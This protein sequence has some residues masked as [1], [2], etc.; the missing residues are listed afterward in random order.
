MNSDSTDGPRD[1]R[2]VRVLVLIATLVLLAA[3]CGSTATGGGADE[4]GPAA[5]EGEGDS[6]QITM[7]RATW[8]TGFMQSYIYRDLLTELGF[9][10]SD[11]SEATLD[12]N[13]FYPALGQ[14][15]YDLWANGWF[16][17]HDIY[18]ERELFSG[19][20]NAEPISPVGTEVAGGAL[21]GYLV[22]R[23]TA[24]EMNLTSMSDLADADV[25]TTFDGNGNG[26]A[27]LI[28][29]NDGWGCNSEINEH[30]DKLDWGGNVEQMVGDYFS[31]VNELADKIDAGEP[32]L[33][34]TWTPNWTVECWSPA[35]TSCGSSHLHCPTTRAIPP[36]K[37]WRGARRVTPA[38]IWAGWSTTSGSWPT[39]T[40]WRRT[41]RRPSCW[42]PSRSRSTTSMRRT[43][44]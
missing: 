27:D 8:N 6:G 19:D 4:G 15:E 43:R 25:A 32:V 12:P 41:R 5:G 3:A 2:S 9:E 39:T 26:K 24:E 44:R 30:I 29:C 38:A 1:R 42:R 37:A 31:Q 28:G 7:A 40:S 20:Q 22:D 14:G 18:L 34:Y 36:P 17:L 23:K 10:V 21:Q 16:P 33:F 11:P 13:V 35:R